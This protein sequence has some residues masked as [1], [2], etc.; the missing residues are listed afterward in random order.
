MATASGL[1]FLRPTL[2]MARANT[3]VVSQGDRSMRSDRAR[4]DF[5]VNGKDVRV[6]VLSDSYDCA[7]GAFDVG[8]P[9][10]R[11]AQDIA[12]GDL[13]RD[14][15]L[16]KDLETA[17]S[18]DCSD[19]GR[20]MMQIIHDVAPGAPLAFYTAF[21]SQEDFAAGIRALAKAG[22]K[23]IVDDI[24]YLRGAHVRRRHHRAGGR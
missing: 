11:A 6:G 15:L 5:G 4:R 12:N 1:K 8:A 7:P 19:E 23:V 20:A 17:P 22:S 9:F 21:V 24:I 16:L 2:A 14:V 10:T 13:P 18:N 3:G